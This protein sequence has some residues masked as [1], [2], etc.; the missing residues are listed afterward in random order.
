MSQASLLSPLVIASLL[1]V[2]IFKS[3]ELIGFIHGPSSQLFATKQQIIHYNILTRI[4][5]DS[6]QT[7][8]W[9][10]DI[11]ATAEQIYNP[12]YDLSYQHDRVTCVLRDAGVIAGLFAVLRTF[13][14]FAGT[15]ITTKSQ[16]WRNLF[17][18]IALFMLPGMIGQILISRMSPIEVLIMTRGSL[19]GIIESILFVG[20]C[21]FKSILS[22]HDGILS[23]H[24]FQVVGVALALANFFL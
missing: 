11:A 4:F 21:S 16:R 24:D 12:H 1:V 19:T 22:Q 18:A 10:T 13:N 7:S 9:I 15:E 2:V 17:I 3:N 6:P 5:S 20:Y 8:S 23:I 14:F